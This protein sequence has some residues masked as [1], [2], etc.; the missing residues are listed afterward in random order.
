M[1]KKALISSILTIAVCV[2]LIAGATFALFT[3]R[4]DVNIAVTAGNVDMVA[5][6]QNVQLYSAEADPNLIAG[7]P[8]VLVDENGFTYK[9]VN[10][11]H[12]GM[13]TNQGT[14]ITADNTL[15]LVSVTPGDKVTFEIKINNQSNVLIKWRTVVWKIDDT[16]LFDGLNITIGDYS[17]Y[18]G[19]TKY[20][21]WQPWA[22]SAVEN[23][24]T[25]ETTVTVSV[26][27][28]IDATNEYQGKTCKIG[29][30]VE[31]VQSNANVED[32]YTYE[33]KTNTYYIHSEAGMMLI[34]Q[35]LNSISTGEGRVA[36]FK[37]TA[38]MNMDRYKDLNTNETVKWEPISKMWVNFDGQNHTVSNLVCG[39]DAAGRSGFFGYAGGVTIENITFEN[40]TAA[41]SQ[42]GIVAGSAEGAT[43]SNVT[44]AGTENTV[45][46]MKAANPEETTGAVGAI[47]G[48]A[49]SMQNT[50]NS[51]TVVDGA[52]ITVNYNELI[53]RAIYKNEYAYTIINDGNWDNI[54]DTGYVA[55]NATY[56]TDLSKCVTAAD[57]AIKAVGKR[58]TE[59]TVE[60]H[61]QLYNVVGATG[62]GYASA[63]DDVTTH[64]YLK[65][66][67]YLTKTNGLI[68]IR[69]KN[70]I[71]EGLG[72]V[73]FIKGHTNSHVFTVGDNANVTFKNI[74]IDGMNTAK[75]GIYVRNNSVLTLD[76]CTIVKTGASSIQV[77]EASDSAHGKT[78]TSTVKL[79]D[80]DVESIW[81]IASPAT[82]VPAGTQDTFVKVLY[83]DDST[84]GYFE[85]QSQTTKPENISIGRVE[86]EEH[87]DNS[88][89]VGITIYAR[90]DAELTAAQNLLK[91]NSYFWNKDVVV[92][93]LENTYTKAY[94]FYQYPTWNGNASGSSN[95]KDGVTGGGNT[96]EHTRI[97]FVGVGNVVFTNTFELTGW[98]QA[99][100]GFTMA[101]ASTSFKNITFQGNG[102]I[103]F[104][105]RA[106]ANNVT[107]TNCRFYDS[108]H[109][110]LGYSGQNAVG[111]IT[112][113]TCTFENGN[114][115]S[116]YYE[117][118]TIT[119]CTV[120]NAYNGFINK[121]KAG[122]V[123]VEDCSLIECTEYFLR[124]SN[125]DVKVN[126]TGCTI[127]VTEIGTETG[128]VVFRGS[129]EYA[130]FDGCTLNNTNA[131]YKNTNAEKSV[132]IINGKDA[133]GN[134]AVVDEASLANA[135]AQGGEVKLYFDVNL[136]GSLVI[137]ANSTT[138]I[139][140]SL[141]RNSATPNVVELDLN[142]KT[143]TSTGLDANGKK[144]HVIVN[145]G[146]L[147]IKNGTVKS[148]GVNGGSAIYNKGTLTIEN[149]DVIGA[150]SNTAVGTASYALNTEGANSK[151]VIKNANISGR[152][153]IGATEGAEVEINGGTYH[154]TEVAGGHA[155]YAVDEGTVVVING[156]TFSEGY[157]ASA[158]N[159]GM[160]QIYAGDNAKV[161]VNGGTFMP[162][163]CANGYDLC[164]DN[165]GTIVI[166]GGSFAE[167]PSNQNGKN[168]VAGDK[169]VAKDPATGTHYVTTGDE[170]VAP[171]V[172]KDGKTYYVSTIE[173]LDWVRTQAANNRNVFNGCTIK[174]EADLDYEGAT[175]API[176]V[177][178][179][180]KPVFDGQGHTIS[181]FVVVN[182]EYKG[183]AGLFSGTVK[184]VNLNV[185]NANV[186]G[187]YSGVLSGKM[188]G[189]IDNCKV[190]NSTVNGTYWQSGALVGQYNAG[191]VTNCTVDN[192]TVNGLSAVGL[193]VGI[194]NEEAGGGT[195][196][197]ENCTVKNSEIVQTGS[198][199]ASYDT[200][201]GILV[202]YVNTSSDYGPCTVYINNCKMENNT[203]RGKASDVVIGETNSNTIVV[204]DGTKY[205]VA[206]AT[207]LKEAVAAGA[208]D[209]YLMAGEY[210]ISG[211]SGKTLTINGT[212]DVV[213]KVMNEGE[214][215]CDG[216]FDSAIV[217]FN[218]VTI[219]TTAN[220]GNYKG[221]TR[222]TAT[223]NDCKFFGAY[224]SH[225]VQT[226]N[227]CEFDFNNGYFWTWGATAVTFNECVFSGTSKAI[228][229]HGWASQEITLNKCTFAA[230]EKGYASSG[231]I[232][233]SAIEID[234]AGTNTYTIEI[235]D[236]KINENYAGWARIKDA[237]T[238]HSIK[239]DGAY[240]V[241]DETMFKAAINSGEEEIEIILAKDIS[242]DIGTGWKM[243]TEATKSISIKGIT[244]TVT[245]NLSNTYRS[246]F[247]MANPDG[248]LYLSDLVLTNAHA[249]T[250]FFDYTT[251]FNCDLVAENV[252]FAKSP[253]VDSGVTAQFTDCNFS[254][255]G[256]DIYGLWI[257]SGSNVT[258]IGGELT[259]D[260]GFKIADEDSAKE[261][262]KLTVSGTK[263]NNS[264]KAAI[265]VTTAYG[266]EITL[267]G[268]DITNCGAD[269][270]NAV[271]IDDGR[272]ANED[273]VVVTGGTVII[274]P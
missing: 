71:I 212:K 72:E 109:I 203:L 260:R 217:T 241:L 249:G 218:G 86:D 63:N 122:T 255:A 100:N 257:M 274:E 254:Q 74:N 143:I 48:I 105:A 4:E 107:F 50:N 64:I 243:G 3:D 225:M 19:G 248:K 129:N 123:T 108:T 167:D 139:T 11:T 269:S 192:C 35:I 197:I 170:F 118:L 96:D 29:Y 176:H 135:L 251:H 137:P 89:P 2:S 60:N 33:E 144:A 12:T 34:P 202:G 87:L 17:D 112:F 79:I 119:N 159:W 1:K 147:S 6:I 81:L 93:I 9:H 54:D 200:L 59:I 231:T 13:F 115:L 99:G 160:Y 266:A 155:V 246:Y 55:T 134:W 37:L 228:L 23:D 179:D 45:S 229:A 158:N 142:G 126:V 97:K 234:P 208:T 133:T 235:K 98:G 180:P 271:W 230:T 171:G 56:F 110:K 92:K 104:T 211:C 166:N 116:D 190:T 161:T 94:N 193:L 22:P 188:Y 182:T 85:K 20:S 5:T 240:L 80:T 172:T 39:T 239:I 163:D 175:I 128:L 196:K 237:S 68:D 141:L 151:V 117:T 83:D 210:D 21:N 205:Y 140:F 14:A 61:A 198:F 227:N 25:Q 127:N 206:T 181:N 273:T 265:L 174:L 75:H 219:D 187:D 207:K 214:D 120:K 131:Y 42:A 53:T 101:K 156:G 28:P 52:K 270:T 268:L 70:V 194:F 195:R 178:S 149:V 153:A 177:W 132:L 221:Y 66:G 111:A 84:V 103:Q 232:W 244:D 256:T 272:T 78:T 245:L 106:A 114:C 27:L 88:D 186:T 24:P 250:H 76:G 226:F 62:Y 57:D 199:G 263:F 173:G 77:D 224:T 252:T 136:T 191:N 36:N 220:N 31:A 264:K 51:I 233:T 130:S 47:V 169:N 154:T 162:W 121:A 46:Y 242:V 15:E 41:G 259:T 204:V 65:E 38:D 44:I 125:I 49:A 216:G 189:D 145:E 82:S 222:L 164:T 148:T 258:V 40:V 253:L 30:R 18:D 113:D 26:E 69:D 124:T 138:P 183:N 90:N 247:N 16:G 8:D 168:F 146:A 213:L 165:T 102:G 7:D 201:F 184:I 150:P 238:G 157:A 43:L 67:D 209:I 73:N 10:T 215:G 152:G 223:F 261:L 185:D 262:T 236:C 267:N 32:P 91:T 95:L 58:T